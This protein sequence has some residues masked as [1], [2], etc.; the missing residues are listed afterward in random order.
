MCPFGDVQNSVRKK[1]RIL[2]DSAGNFT[3]NLEEME[4]RK[5]YGIPWRRNS[6]DTQLRSLNVVSILARLYFIILKSNFFSE[7]TL[8]RIDHELFSYWEDALIN[9]L[10]IFYPFGGAAFGKVLQ[11]QSPQIP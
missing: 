10:L 2:R 1:H 9:L 5:T 11:S 7:L 4:V 3:R 6:V 8:N